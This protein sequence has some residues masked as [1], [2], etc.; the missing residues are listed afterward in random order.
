LIVSIGFLSGVTLDRPDMAISDGK[1]AFKK[2]SDFRGFYLV[3]NAETEEPRYRFLIDKALTSGID[4]QQISPSYLSEF[5]SNVIASMQHSD[6]FE[7][8]IISIADDCFKIRP[9][10]LKLSRI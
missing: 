8:R 10:I 9:E 7:L 4:R 6:S 3:V 5:A 2:C 1:E